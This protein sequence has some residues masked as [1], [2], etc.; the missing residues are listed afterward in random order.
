MLIFLFLLLLAMIALLSRPGVLKR[1]AITNTLLDSIDNLIW[2]R[3]IALVLMIPVVLM[4]MVAKPS[5]LLWNGTAA[6]MSGVI[7]V[8]V[9]IL[10]YLIARA[11]KSDAFVH[12]Y[13]GLMHPKSRWFA[14][15]LITV[16]YMSSYEIIM[17]GTLLHYLAARFDLIIAVTINSAMY[18]VMH[19]IKN[20]KEAFL[21]FPLGLLL[22]YLTISTK[23]IWPAVIFHTVMALCFEYWYHQK[24][25]NAQ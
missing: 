18:S 15:L 13:A 12:Q 11:D 25:L 4:E 22:C 3:A 10:S 7:V 14:Y 19:M 23:S 1:N 2:Q 17:R 5:W 21:S 9:P 16:L 8:V 24:V 20:K 6:W